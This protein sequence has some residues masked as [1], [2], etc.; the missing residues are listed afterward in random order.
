MI[1]TRPYTKDEI[2]K[3]LEIRAEKEKIKIEKE[4]LEYL[5]QIGEK[6]S[7]RHAIQL[8]APAYEVAKENKRERISVEDIKF[9]EERFVDVKRSVEYMKSL[10]EKFLK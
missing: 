1:N 4:A 5:T 3:I 10:E 7:L 8:L 9:V 2:K 6:T